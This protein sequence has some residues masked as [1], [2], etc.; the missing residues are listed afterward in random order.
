MIRK[1]DFRV[2]PWCRQSLNL[3]VV[4]TIGME[5][6]NP[7][8]SSSHTDVRLVDGTTY[9]CDT[10]PALRS[11]SI[12]FS[13]RSRGVMMRLNAKRQCQ[14]SL[15]LMGG[16]LILTSTSKSECDV[17]GSG[18]LPTAAISLQISLSSSTFQCEIFHSFIIHTIKHKPHCKFKPSPH[19]T[20]RTPLTTYLHPHTSNSKYHIPF[21]LHTGT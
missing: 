20:P 13:R 15:R 18:A 2:Y 3:G 7:Q 4:S 19:K 17:K 6:P 5:A 1:F 11:S 21:R 8:A 16:P 12:R 9:L 14:S 10:G